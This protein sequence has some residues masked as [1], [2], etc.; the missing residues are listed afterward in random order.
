MGS[1][2][3]G[4]SR[5]PNEAYANRGGDALFAG[6]ARGPWPSGDGAPDCALYGASLSARAGKEAPPFEA[7]REG[8]VARRKERNET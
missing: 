1:A 6:S 7:G 4:L 3:D 5:A 2:W 8:E